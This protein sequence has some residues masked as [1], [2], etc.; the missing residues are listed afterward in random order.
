[1]DDVKHHG[2]KRNEVEL[3]PKPIMKLENV[4]NKETKLV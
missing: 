2:D 4:Q 1:M 3:Q